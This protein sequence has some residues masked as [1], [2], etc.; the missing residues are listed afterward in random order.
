VSVLALGGL[1]CGCR[2]TADGDTLHVYPCATGHGQH[3][4]ALFAEAKR[5][6]DELGIEFDEVD[7]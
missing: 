2:V 1:P 3:Y 7:E 4:D 6:A 5:L